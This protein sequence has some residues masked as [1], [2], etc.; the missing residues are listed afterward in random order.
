MIDANFDPYEELIVLK[1]N[2]KELIN[3]HNHHDEALAQM[4]R[5]TNQILQRLHS[6]EKQVIVLSQQLKAGNK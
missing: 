5:H 2:T 3:A 4:A 1:H 6:L